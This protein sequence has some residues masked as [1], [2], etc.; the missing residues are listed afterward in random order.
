MTRAMGLDLGTKTIGIALSDPMY[1]IAQAHG[2]IQ[3]KSLPEDIDALRKII[4]EYEVEE[5]ILGLPLNM[6]HTYGPS[7]QRA[8]TF[9]AQLEQLLRKSVIYQD[10]RLST[11]SADRVLI[12][13][14][15]RRE[16]RKK[17]VDSVA[18]T[19]ILQTW[20]DGRKRK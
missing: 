18:A 15:V 11:V 10:E 12:E 2:T 17:H 4:E 5:I 1:W 16:H 7:A 20:L 14:G 13:S 9:G 6:N 3:R 8:K 19:F